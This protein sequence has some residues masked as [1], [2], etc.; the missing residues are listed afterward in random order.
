MCAIEPKESSRGAHTYI[1]IGRRE[2]E[3]E[4]EKT[5]NSNGDKKKTH[6]TKHLFSKLIRRRDAHGYLSK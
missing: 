4:E 3:E 1:S 6:Y 5:N 2:K